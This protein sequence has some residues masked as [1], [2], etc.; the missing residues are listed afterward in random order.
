MQATQRRGVVR[1]SASTR[2]KLGL[3]AG[4]LAMGA[5]A[6]GAGVATASPPGTVTEFP[7]GLPAGSSPW[8]LAMGPD[9]NVWFTDIGTTRAVGRITPAGTI[10]EFSGGLSNFPFGITPG[11]DGNMWSADARAI[12]RITPAGTIGEFSFG[13]DPFSEPQAITLGADGNLWFTDEGAPKHNTVGLITPSGTISEPPLALNPGSR[14]EYIAPGADGNIWFTDEGTSPAIG[15]ITP[16]TPLPCAPSV[17][18]FTAGLKAGSLP[19]GIAPGP[20]GNMW[21]TDVG[22]TGAIGRITP[23]G[24]IEE[25]STGLS[26]GAEPQFIAPGA[27]GKM[28]FTDVRKSAEAIGQV[29][30][31]A[32]AG[33]SPAISE[34]AVNLPVGSKPFGIAPGPDGNMWFTDRGTTKAIGQVGTGTSLAVQSSPAVVGGGLVGTLQTCA[35]ATWATWAGVQPSASLFGFDGYRWQLDGVPTASGQTYIPTAGQVGHALTCSETVTYPLPLLVSAPATSAAVSVNAPPVALPILAARPG[36]P[37]ITAL[38]Q[39]APRWRAGRK[40]ARITA[41]RGAPLGTTFSFALN[42]SA[43]VRFAFTQRAPGR[44]VAGRCVAKTTKNAKRRACTR[45]LTRGTLSPF[46]GHTRSVNKVVFQGRV[47]AR[48]TLRPGRYTL[49]VTA[50]NAA[51]LRS[52][53]R[54][55]SFTIVGV[56]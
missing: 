50:T 5:L 55:L 52:V 29:T 21:F 54:S 2:A 49:T 1:R 22:A 8:Q 44:S 25:F 47:S 43:R 53:P 34:P 14:P 28:W 23:A 15:R 36:R 32:A 30:P 42:Q 20:D 24:T 40:L 16:C 31:C 11:P 19:E 12:G 38:R 33:C 13:L 51:G 45:T 48:R 39:S 9:G 18:E 27:D 35:P 10:S 6:S 3:L 56:G 37:A 26:S 46:N 7:A 4:L 41:R 17:T